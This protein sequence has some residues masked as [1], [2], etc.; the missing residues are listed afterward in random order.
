MSEARVEFI[1]RK[2]ALLGARTRASHCALVWPHYR[3]IYRPYQLARADLCQVANMEVL[4]WGEQPAP[5]NQAFVAGWL[6]CPASFQGPTFTAGSQYCEST[7]Q[8][9]FQADYA[10]NTNLGGSWG[11][12]HQ[13]QTA[14]ALTVI[15]DFCGNAWMVTEI[16]E[17]L[18]LYWSYGHY[19]LGTLPHPMH[20]LPQATHWQSIATAL[21]LPQGLPIN[22][23]N[24]LTSKE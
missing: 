24:K 3:A 8:R 7:F 22:A 5:T 9:Q 15:C 12:V 23:G 19:L 18:R 13:S 16:A 21:P 10:A 11:S 6:P 4:A 17:R 1:P 2:S 14:A 20:Q